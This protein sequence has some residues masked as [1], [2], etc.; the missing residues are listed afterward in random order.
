MTPRRIT[1]E[2]LAQ[3]VLEALQVELEHGDIEPLFESHG[4]AFA[5]FVEINNRVQAMTSANYLANHGEALSE[6]AMGASS[7]G[8]LRGF[9]AGLQLRRVLDSSE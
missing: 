1:L 6:T 8:F 3:A 9:L 2:E 4:I 5:D 7:A